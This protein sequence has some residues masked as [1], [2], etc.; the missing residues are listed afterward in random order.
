MHRVAGGAGHVPFAAHHTLAE[1]KQGALLSFPVEGQR[2]HRRMA[3]PTSLNSVRRLIGSADALWISQAQDMPA[4]LTVTGLAAPLRP[5]G[6]CQEDPMRSGLQVSLLAD[7]AADAGLDPCK[8][9]VVREPLP[10][11]GVGAGLLGRSFGVDAVA[12]G[13]AL[14][15][16]DEVLDRAS[17]VPQL[18]LVTGCAELVLGQGGEFLGKGDLRRFLLVRVQLPRA[19]AG[20]A[21]VE[22]LL[23]LDPIVP[24]LG[25]DL[26][27][28]DMTVCTG[29]PIIQILALALEG[30]RGFLPFLGESPRA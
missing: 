2:I 16:L 9:R 8:T 23:I 30:R 24:R 18:S 17:V 14:S 7:V 21:G 13:A 12:I 15:G 5:K 28:I 25:E 4:P 1:P 27:L 3:G 11:G 22:P 20:L 29:L 10:R 6:L 26:G 19:V